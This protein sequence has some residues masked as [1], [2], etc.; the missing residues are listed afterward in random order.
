VAL[1]LLVMSLIFNIV[2]RRLVV[3]ADARPATAH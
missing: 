2:A 3:G 1:I